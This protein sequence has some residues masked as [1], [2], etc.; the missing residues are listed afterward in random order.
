MIKPTKK[1]RKIFINFIKANLILLQKKTVTSTVNRRY[2]SIQKNVV[3]RLM[4]R[5][6]VQAKA[7]K[8]G[9]R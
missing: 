9:T 2:D 7:F 3:G 5:Y 1:K 8:M 6:L 4:D